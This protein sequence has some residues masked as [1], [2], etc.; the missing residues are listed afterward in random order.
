MEKGYFC[1]FQAS[2]VG[3]KKAIAQTENMQPTIA[4][5]M[6]KRLFVCMLNVDKFLAVWPW[7]GF[8]DLCRPFTFCSNLDQIESKCPLK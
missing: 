4:L 7:F 2:G 5:S 6:K 3:E 8:Y 1:N